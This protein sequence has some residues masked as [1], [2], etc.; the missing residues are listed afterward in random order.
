MQKPDVL[1]D[2]QALPAGMSRTMARANLELQT[3][4]HVLIAGN[5]NRYTERLKKV[6]P[7][8]ARQAIAKWLTPDKVFAMR[9][10]PSPGF[11]K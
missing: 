7:S 5:F 8:A 9:V 1:L 3:L 4:Q 11:N 2:R 6:E 10:V